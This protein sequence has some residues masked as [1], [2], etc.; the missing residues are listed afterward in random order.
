MTDHA[1]P[2]L[3]SRDLEATAAFYAGF[4]F[5]TVFRDDGWMVLRRGVLPLEFFPMP[6]LDPARS[7]FMCSLRVDDVDELYGAVLG[8]GVAEGTVGFPRLHP[9]VLQPWGLRVGHLVDI[10]GTQ[11]NLIG[12]PT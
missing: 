11:L 12:N 9:V 1:V 3:P 4:G 7:N 10:D 2:N 8:S 5:E 6:G